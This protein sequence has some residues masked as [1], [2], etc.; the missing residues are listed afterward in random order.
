VPAAHAD[1]AGGRVLGKGGLVGTKLPDDAGED[2]V[3][4][5]PLLLGKAPAP[6]HEAII[7]QAPNRDL[8]IRQG[9]WKLIFLSTGGRALHDLR[10]E[11]G[12]RQDVAA[13]HPQ[14]VERLTALM[15][16]YVAEGRS[17]AGA[18]Q[19]QEAPITVDA[20]SGGLKPKGRKGNRSPRTD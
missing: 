7:H 9:P 20:T 1:R 18:P 14:V 3:S 8:A 2:S 16:R 17:T 19:P 10:S 11:L 13:A 12:E 4:L 6:V 15:K 5:L